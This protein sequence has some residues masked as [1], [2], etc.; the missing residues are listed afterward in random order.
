MLHITLHIRVFEEWQI[1]FCL[2]LSHIPSE[3]HCIW[4]WERASDSDVH[5]ASPIHHALSPGVPS[6]CKTN[7]WPKCILSFINRGHW[8]VC[9]H[10][11]TYFMRIFR[12]IAR[13]TPSRS[14]DS[15]KFPLKTTPYKASNWKDPNSHS[16]LHN[17]KNFY[18]SLVLLLLDLGLRCSFIRL[19]WGRVKP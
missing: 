16:I 1:T 8:H 7:Q 2:L 18:L 13:K 6:P 9:I 12:A 11:Q 19:G 3:T 17:H 14:C 5:T 4:C 15:R 10:A